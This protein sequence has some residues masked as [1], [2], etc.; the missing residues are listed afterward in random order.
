MQQHFTFEGKQW[1]KQILNIANTSQSLH[2]NKVGSELWLDQTEIDF[3]RCSGSNI[4]HYD[5]G[6]SE[7]LSSL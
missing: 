2:G 5:N 1:R 6:I 7:Y 3:K 4:M